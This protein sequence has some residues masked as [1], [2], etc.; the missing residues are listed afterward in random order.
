MTKWNIDKGRKVTG[1]IIHLHRKKRRFQRVSLPLLTKLEKEKK[2]IDR[3]RGGIK[4]IRLPSAEFANVID[5][6]TNKY[7]KV[8]IL[9]VLRNDANP[10]YVR[11]G[12][13]TKGTI[14]KTELGDAKVISRPSQDGIVNATILTEKKEEK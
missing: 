2:R 11:R 1:G 3:R 9:H 8:K 14:I 12:I 7:K 5:T 6:K 10:Q 4:K 13:I